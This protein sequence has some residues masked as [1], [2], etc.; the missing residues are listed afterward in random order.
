M[1]DTFKK[2]FPELPLT[3]YLA[4]LI[5]DQHYQAWRDMRTILAHRAATAG[6]TIQYQGP[7]L[8]QPDEP[9]LFVTLWASDLPLDATR[10]ASQY[11]WLR[12]VINRG[13]EATAVFTVQQLAY[14]EDQLPRFM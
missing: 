10:L 8:F 11:A 4:R 12:E 2:T 5:D 1:R 3:E 7:F 14:T 9:P 13:I 6:R